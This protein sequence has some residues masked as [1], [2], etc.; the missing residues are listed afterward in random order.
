M[1]TLL[2]VTNIFTPWCQKI[3]EYF[4]FISPPNGKRHLTQQKLSFF[5]LA[6]IFNI[7]RS[8]VQMFMGGRLFFSFLICRIISKPILNLSNQ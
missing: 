7:R 8:A 2:N 1:Y 5:D 6:D 4:G 3:F